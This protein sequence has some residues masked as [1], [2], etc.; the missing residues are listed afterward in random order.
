MY[1]FVREQLIVLPMDMSKLDNVFSAFEQIS[2]KLNFTDDQR[3]VQLYVAIIELENNHEL[4][5]IYYL[6][7]RNKPIPTGN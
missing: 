6:T 4:D 3:F 1:E 7:S 5:E 2:T